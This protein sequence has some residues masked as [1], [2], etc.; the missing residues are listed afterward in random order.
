L[1]KVMV[2]HS[3]RKMPA[4]WEVLDVRVSLADK[5]DLRISDLYA[6]FAGLRTAA[7]HNGTSVGVVEDWKQAPAR[8][9]PA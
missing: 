8:L 9:L 3:S 7:D 5:V 1:S 6:Q 4:T 2:G